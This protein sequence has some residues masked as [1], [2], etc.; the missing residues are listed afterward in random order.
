METIS[1]IT[2]IAIVVA[3]LL[4]GIFIMSFY[5]GD[6]EEPETTTEAMYH[7]EMIEKMGHKEKNPAMIPHS[8]VECASM[9]CP[10]HKDR[11]YNSVRGMDPDDLEAELQIAAFTQGLGDIEPLDQKTGSW[12]QYIADTEISPEVHESNR[13]FV[14]EVSKYNTARAGFA[15]LEDNPMTN[16]VGLFA[17]YYIPKSPYARQTED[18]DHEAFKKNKRFTY[19]QTAPSYS[20]EPQ[21]GKMLSMC[22]DYY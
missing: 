15:V 1:I 10:I 14:K 20:M 16:Y 21:I 9:D 3:L 18:I 22:D 13:E 17:P 4:V 5:M 19:G 7:K 11:E 8:R 12:Q 2:V 6:E